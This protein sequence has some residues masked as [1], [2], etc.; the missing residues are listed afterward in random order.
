MFKMLD[1]VRIK[2][3]QNTGFIVYIDTDGGTK[4]PIYC[5]EIL[6]IESNDLSEVLIW[7]EEDEIEK[8]EE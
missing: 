6:E 5:V 1:K 8:I 4:P 3:N 7:Y 2:S